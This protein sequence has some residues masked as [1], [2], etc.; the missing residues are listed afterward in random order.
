MFRCIRQQ[1]HKAC[2]FDSG[3]QATLVFGASSRLAAGLNFAAIRNVFPQEAA[4]I[5]VINFANMIVAEL[6]NFAAGTTITPA[7][8]PLA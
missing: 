1:G 7:L 2:L 5:F 3:A 6:T 8:A 4:R